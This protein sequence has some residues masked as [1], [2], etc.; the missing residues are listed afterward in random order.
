MYLCHL[1]QIMQNKYG[2]KSTLVEIL[3]ELDPEFSIQMNQTPVL[4]FA[5][6]QGLPRQG[7]VLI[8]VLKIQIIN[9]SHATFK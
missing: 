6:N 7:N 1:V 2:G 9:S 5:I 3:P 8:Q 4:Q